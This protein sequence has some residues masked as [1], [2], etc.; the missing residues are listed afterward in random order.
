MSTD[1]ELRIEDLRLP[2]LYIVVD[3]YGYGVLRKT[4]E[5]QDDADAMKAEQER[6]EPHNGPHHVVELAPVRFVD[7]S[8]VNDA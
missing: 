2:T 4:Y 5:S 8:E 3:R 7:E 1:K 6:E